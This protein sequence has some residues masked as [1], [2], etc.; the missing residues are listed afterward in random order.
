M[1]DNGYATRITA[2]LFNMSSFSNAHVNW[3]VKATQDRGFGGIKAPGRKCEGWCV[4]EEK[5]MEGAAR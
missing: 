3:N 2:W 5:W 4:I 1:E